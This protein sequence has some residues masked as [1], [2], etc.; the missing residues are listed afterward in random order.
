MYIDILYVG[1]R[2]KYCYLYLVQ[3]IFGPNT[4]N[5]INSNKSNYI[6]TRL[7]AVTYYV[8]HMFYILYYLSHYGPKTAQWNIGVRSLN[9]Y[10]VVF[11][12]TD[13]YSPADDCL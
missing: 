4:Y 5:N 10:I 9:T 13:Q 7:V 1:D 6:I 8:S 3:I 11:Y 2:N 12:S